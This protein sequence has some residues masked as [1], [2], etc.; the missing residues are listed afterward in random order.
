MK[1]IGLIGSNND[2]SY[3]KKLLE[4]CKMLMIDQI[5]IEIISCNNIPIFNLELSIYDNKFL[6]DLSDKIKNSDGIIISTEEILNTIP[7][8]LKSLLEWMS[9]EIHPFLNK[10]VLVL[11]ISKDEN[12]TRRS[13]MQL[14]E[15]LSSPG[16]ECFVIPGNE[17]LMS[18]ASEKFDVDGRLIHEQSQD[19]LEHCLL[20][21]EKYARLI[22]TLDLKNLESK[23][24][25]TLKSGGYI[26]L[27]D[28]N[29]D[30]TSGA[31]DY[32]N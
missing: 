22:N 31:T 10:P 28:P 15:I 30:G 13:Q 3:P 20:R 4:Y 18:M 21:F 24:T 17:F 32:W 26:N 14:K 9:Y 29:S 19:Y 27:D 16:L 23:Y 25:L 1:F 12:P 8:S 6:I 11:G 2:K 7:S 5:D